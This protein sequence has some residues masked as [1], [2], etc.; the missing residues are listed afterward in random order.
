MTFSPAIK[1]I[2]H[3][4][5]S[6]ELSDI[7]EHGCASGC[8]SS[9]IYYSENVEFFDKYDSD[10][11][12]YLRDVFGEDFMFHLV[13]DCHDMTD[14]K[15]KLVWTFIELVASDYMNQLSEGDDNLY[16]EVA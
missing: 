10:I 2:L 8:A 9:H 5:D 14:M 13:T 1:S 16:G 15:N 7:A 4:Y 12:D 6:E 3:T 11:Q